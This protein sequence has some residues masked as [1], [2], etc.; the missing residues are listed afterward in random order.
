MTE[1]DGMTP[2]E[3]IQEVVG[4]VVGTLIVEAIEGKF[5]PFRL[6]NWCFRH[7]DYWEDRNERKYIERMRSHSFAYHNIVIPGVKS[8]RRPKKPR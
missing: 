4:A 6:Y 1:E 5:D 2:E 7:I 3:F 8:M